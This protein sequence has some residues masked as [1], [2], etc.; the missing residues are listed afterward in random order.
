VGLAYILLAT[1][2]ASLYSILQKPFLKK[3]HT[4][5]ATTYVIWGGT[6]FLLLYSPVLKHDLLKAS[7]GNT[8]TVIYLGMFPA[9][10]GYIAWN[11]ALSQISVSHAVSFLYFVPFLATLFE[12]LYLGEV[13]TLFSLVGGLLAI[14]GVGL[15]NY[16]Y[17]KK[18]LVV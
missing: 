6:L 12:W 4:I 1:I 16:S 8:I 11:Y 17:N 15:V 3:Y 18:R 9:T 10:I 7:L 2:A 14:L 13:P 5:Q